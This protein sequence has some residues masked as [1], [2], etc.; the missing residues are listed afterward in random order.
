MHER[1]S[2][3][4]SGHQETIS[5]SYDWIIESSNLQTEVKSAEILIPLSYYYNNKIVNFRWRIESRISE[6]GDLIISL[7]NLNWEAFSMSHSHYIHWKSDVE[8]SGGNSTNI[9]ET[10][11]KIAQDRFKPG[12]RLTRS[13]S[14]Q[15]LS[16]LLECRNIRFH[17]TIKVTKPSHLS[18]MNLRL[19]DTG[20]VMS[21]DVFLER[22]DC[23]PSPSPLWSP[24]LSHLNPTFKYHCLRINTPSSSS[25]IEKKS[26]GLP[27]VGLP[28]VWLT[29]PH[30][31]PDSAT[32]L[33]S[34]PSSPEHTRR[35]ATV[36]R[37]ESV[38]DLCDTTFDLK[39]IEDARRLSVAL[40]LDDDVFVE[41]QFPASQAHPADEG[42]SVT[43]SSC[44]Q[45]KFSSASSAVIYNI[46][47]GKSKQS[48]ENHQRRLLQY[49][50]SQNNE[51][52][53]FVCTL[54]KYL[55]DLQIDNCLETLMMVDNILPHS[56]TRIKILSFIKQNFLAIEKSVQW[57]DFSKSRPEFLQKI[58]Q[59][60][61][62]TPL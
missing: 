25:A 35:E 30:S 56:E 53:P 41:D 37:R 4:C 32:A 57:E 18:P 7:K 52:L 58:V 48:S 1:G 28:R 8:I 11:V 51:M 43:I 12:Q 39:E 29:P 34:L 42:M 17:F 44:S 23:P 38:A 16:T 49:V 45:G 2:L 20:S 61:M 40:T 50:S 6:N 31:V 27:G 19:S 9:R 15:N 21:D 26:S 33:N 62:E 46:Y 22:G 60:T 59:E 10:F 24:Q 55:D 13:I 3:L 36:M 5:S 14:R 47:S 54:Q